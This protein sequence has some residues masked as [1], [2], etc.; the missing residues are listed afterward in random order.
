VFS[1]ILLKLNKGATVAELTEKF[2]S[3]VQ[4]VRMTGKGGSLA[5]TV[6]VA[7]ATRGDV[8]ILMVDAG[9]KVSA[10]EA[11]HRKNVFFSTEDGE[12]CQN[13]PS[14]MELQLGPRAI[15]VLPREV[16]NA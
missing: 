6:K 14:Q 9:V 4:A 3:L 7:P 11:E 10:P 12:L 16:S 5:L 2:R 8:D 1:D 15:E 13:D